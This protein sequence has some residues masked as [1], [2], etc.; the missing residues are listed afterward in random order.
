MQDVNAIKKLFVIP[1]GGVN[2][3]NFPEA[4]V[5]AISLELATIPTYLSTYYSINRSPDQKKMYA[6]IHEKISDGISPEDRKKIAEEF[7]LDVMVYANQTAAIIMSVV[8]EEMLHLALSSNVHQAM[9]SP[10]ELVKISSGLSFPTKLDGHDPLFPINLGKL[11]LD[12]LKTFLQIESPNPFELKRPMLRK[13]VPYKTIGE[14]YD[15]IMSYIVN[16]FEGEF[17][18]DEPQLLP[19]QPFYSENSINTVYYDRDHNPVFTSA[20]DSGGLNGV[21]NKQTAIDALT[22]IVDQGEGHKGG[23]KL[24]LDDNDM[25]IPL[26]V[27]DGKVVFRPEDYDDDGKLE[28]AHFDK[29][30]EAYSLGV[31]YEAKFG[32]YGINFYDLFVY[33]QIDNPK[34]A[35]YA[36]NE[37]LALIAELADAIFTYIILMI[38]TCYHADESTRFKVFMYGIHKSMIWL[39]SELGNAINGE[40]FTKN[41]HVHQGALCFEYF[42]FSKSAES[43]KDQMLALATKLI[44]KSTPAATPAKPNPTSSWAWLLT[45]PAYLN[46]LPDVGLDHSVAPNVPAIPH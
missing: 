5:Q 15:M 3:S 40:T 26:P 10:P 8:I 24:L 37:V 44:A 13:A 41:G 34:L 18:K 6:K 27:V 20:D 46:S 1:Q 33:N 21:F 9:I 23:N 19:D 17:R 31:H 35:D 29:F 32:Q 36:Q 43:P 2:D 12:Q 28:L 25:P 30:L 22:K 42:D 39:L 7:T 4:M 11:S 38:E 16:D 45:D 14:F